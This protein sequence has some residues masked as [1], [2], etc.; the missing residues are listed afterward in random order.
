MDDVIR[1]THGFDICATSTGV[2]TNTGPD[3]QYDILDGS[4]YNGSAALV[5]GKSGPANSG[6]VGQ[7]AFKW[8]GPGLFTRVFEPQT[9]WYFGT[10]WQRAGAAGGAGTNKWFF[11]SAGSTVCIALQSESNGKLSIISGGTSANG[12]GAL[13]QQTTISFPIGTWAGYL[14]FTASGFGLGNTLTYELWLDDVLLLTGTTSIADI[15]DRYTIGSQGDTGRIFDNQYICDGQ[16]P[17]PW[18]GRLGPIRITSLSPNADLSGSWIPTPAAPT[19][20]QVQDL[21]SDPHGSPDGDST[22]ASP[23]SIG[24]QQFFQ[25]ESSPCFGRVLGV[26]V[27]LCF[28]GTSGSAS[29]QALLLQ[30]GAPVLIGTPNVTG[31]YHTAQAI[32][33]QSPATGTFLTDA[34][35]SSGFWGVA[36]LT[37]FDLRVTQMFLEKITSLRSVPYNC[38]RGSYAY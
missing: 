13:L 35:I 30:T 21:P 6:P 27:N 28:R 8:N 25:V 14:E 17:A 7:A 5:A 12:T 38:G 23:D 16:G 3:L 24:G 32:L 31:I 29:C 15:P 2:G 26:A 11:L 19:F 4:W 37:S 34:E 36:T 10:D 1:D 20:Q 9:S 18:N 33:Q 22:Y